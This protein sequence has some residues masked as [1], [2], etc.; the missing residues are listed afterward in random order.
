MFCCVPDPALSPKRKWVG[1]VRRPGAS[2]GGPICN[3]SPASRFLWMRSAGVQAVRLC[4]AR[5]I[6]Q[7]PSHRRDRSPRSPPQVHP[8]EAQSYSDRHF[9]LLRGPDEDTFPEPVAWL[10]GSDDARLP[11]GLG[12]LRVPPRGTAENAEQCFCRNKRQDGV[13]EKLQLFIIADPHSFERLLC[14]L[15]PSLRAVRQGLLQQL[16]TAE[17]MPQQ[18]FEGGNIT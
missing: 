17:R 14:F 4:P 16:G 15:L 5:T 8:P 11:N 6:A 7:D 9:F 18:R 1:R 12:V 3:P 10:P 2:P 13:A